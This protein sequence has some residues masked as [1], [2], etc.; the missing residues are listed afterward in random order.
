[1]APDSAIV[2]FGGGTGMSCLLSGLRAHSSRITAIVTV[3]DNG[4]SSGRLRKEFDMVPPGDIRNCL[5]ALSDGEPLLTRLMQY[6]FTESELDGHS[7]GNLFLTA[8]TR[9]TGSFDTAVRELNRLLEVR[10][11]VLPATGH[12]VSLVATHTDGTKSTGEVQVSASG[13][14]IKSVAIRPRVGQAADD[15]LAAIAEADLIVFG[16]GSLF[17]SVVPNLLVP[18]IAEAVRANDCEKVYV[19]NIM[20]Q[21]GETDHLDLTGHLD[22]L[23]SH[24]KDSF[25]TGVVRNVGEIPDDVRDRYQLGGATLVVG[26]DQVLVERGLRVVT[27]DFVD[28]S[29]WEVSG[30]SVIRHHAERLAD[31]LVKSFL[32]ECDAESSRDHTGARGR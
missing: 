26:D 22:A 16:P 23:E 27:G 1:M 21:P 24:G 19:A 30:S 13:K 15:V 6:R 2:A 11:R 32:R 9:V 29:S 10:G 17:T 14:P 5:V 25:L 12:K 8:L 3:T 28:R 20:T 31:A 7:F 4:G 18:G